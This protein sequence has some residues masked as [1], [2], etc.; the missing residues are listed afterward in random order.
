MNAH[1]KAMVAVEIQDLG[2]AMATSK[3]G[4]ASHPNGLEQ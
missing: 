3:C 1:V 4:S 2:V